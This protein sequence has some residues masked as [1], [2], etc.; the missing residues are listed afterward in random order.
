MVLQS[1]TVPV[2]PIDTTTYVQSRASFLTPDTIWLGVNVGPDKN[3]RFSFCPL[4]RIL[5][6]VPPTSTTNT[7]PAADVFATSARSGRPRR[8]WAARRDFAFTALARSLEYGGFGADHTHQVVPRIDEG[9]CTFVL[10]LLRQRMDV[11]LCLG[12]P[13]QLRFAVAAVR[14]YRRAD[15][16][17]L[18]ERFQRALG[19]RVHREWRGQGLDVKDIRSLRILGPGAGPQQ[20][21]RTRA[22]IVGAHP[23]RR[24]QQA[25]IGLV[26]PL[27]DGDAEPVVERLRHLAGDCDVPAADEDRRHRAHIGLQSRFDAAFD[28]AHER[29]GGRQ[30]LVVG[31]Q[32]RDVDRHPGKDRLFDGWE[33]LG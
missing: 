18:G 6:E 2:Y 9:L 1:R 3:E 23:S 22:S 30:V 26:G 28:A 15:I 24:T 8:R 20:A 29:V 10:K 16:A 27:G 17:M 25:E 5:T 32:Q 7:F 31:E 33:A 11:D 14:R 21:L 12:K 13:C 19:H 4:A